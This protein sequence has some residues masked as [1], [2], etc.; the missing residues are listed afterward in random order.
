MK[1]R[2]NVTISLSQRIAKYSQ[3][4]LIAG[5]ALYLIAYFAIALTR[6]SYPFELEWMEGGS[7][8][9]VQRI[10]DGLSL[11]VSPSLDYVPY[12]YTPFYF[13]LSSL[14][15]HVTGNGFLPLRIV[16]LLSSAGCFAMIFM[17]VHRRT[18]SLFAAF[19]S[20]CLFAATFRISGAWFDLAR[21][22]SLFLFLLL[23]GIYCFGSPNASI[24]TYATPIFLFLSFFAK[25]TALIVAVSLLILAI[26]TRKRSE[27]ILLPLVFVS[28]MAGS[29]LL[30]NSLT[31][32]WYKYYVFDLPAQHAIVKHM[33][34]RFFTIDVLQNLPIAL[35][36]CVI[37]FLRTGADKNASSNT[38]TQDAF[39]IGSLFL[40]SYFS[41]IHSAGYVNCLM[42]VYAGIAIYFGIGLA[43]SL[44]AMG[45]NDNVRTALI[46][47]ALFQFA[48]LFYSPGKQVPSSL[49][50]QQGENLQKLVSGFQGE[51]YLPDH[52]WLLG[53]LN[54][55]TQA[56]EMAVRDIYRAADS[57]QQKQML[58]RDMEAAIAENR[59]EAFIVDFKNFTM[60]SRDFEARYE[61]V[62]SNLSGSAFHPV[63]GGDRRPMYLYVRRSDQ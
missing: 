17:I 37:P 28:L 39:I 11:Y 30:M 54:K 62:N 46:L 53:S 23:A 12:I 55:P 35:L 7:V 33:L 6:I 1:T 31:D 27:R 9:E 24:R 61:L 59:F 58:E 20:A 41:R 3:Y 56:Q 48:N 15:A 13:Y 5:A 10:L 52:P 43:L 18:A 57:N 51:V 60:R 32:G 50:R 40:A 22:D 21:A 34:T 25:Q 16:S 14:V 36:F 8:V 42:P 2:E 29:F 47:A 26:F 4:V 63:T 19:I 44:K 49:D 38:I 45:E